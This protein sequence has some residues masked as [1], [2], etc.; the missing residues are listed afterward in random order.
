MNALRATVLL[1]IS[2]MTIST[3]NI[4]PAA[5]DEDP[6]AAQF[7]FWVGSWALTSGGKQ[8]GTNTI[9]KEYDGAV[10]MERF[11]GTAATALQGMSVSVFDKNTGQWRQTWVDNQG[12]YL[13][14]V[15]GFADEKMILS[16]RTTLQGTDVVQRMV[17][18]NI[19]PDSFDWNWER[20]DDDGATWTTVWPIHY[21]RQPR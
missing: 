19:T 10:I 20:S 1:L 9:T 14:F 18:F 7:D 2:V 5:A 12:A 8:T 17:W 6:R 16:R 21:V 13:D 4:P 3:G 11:V 15:G